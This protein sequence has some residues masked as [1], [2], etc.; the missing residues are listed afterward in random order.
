MDVSTLVSPGELWPPPLCLHGHLPGA[1]RHA[2]H[3]D[4]HTSQPRTSRPESGSSRKCQGEASWRKTTQVHGRP[5]NTWFVL[6]DGSHSGLPP[7][8]G[9]WQ[10]EKQ[11]TRAHTCTLTYV[12]TH[13]IHTH[14]HT[15]TCT[16]VICT[17]RDTH[18]NISKCTHRHRHTQI[19]TCRHTHTDTLS[20]TH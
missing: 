5:F 19:R 20:H 10:G 1:P 4:T 9:G 13:A 3:S 18:A 17:Y 12:C 6:S 14:T 16:T 2:P 8:G 11:K 7:W 15:H